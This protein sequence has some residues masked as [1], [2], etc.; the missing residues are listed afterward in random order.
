MNPTSAPGPPSLIAIDG[1]TMQDV[2][3]VVDIAVNSALLALTVS[4]F[5]ITFLVERELK[6]I[7]SISGIA[8]I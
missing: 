6:S 7:F 4:L 2:P 1:E 3:I 8:L 5:F